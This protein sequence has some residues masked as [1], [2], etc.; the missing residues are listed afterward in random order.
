M[1]VKIVSVTFNMNTIQSTTAVWTSS[2]KITGSETTF[3]TIP[4]CE[5]RRGKD[6]ITVCVFSNQN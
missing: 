6:G 4:R 1:S 3:G 2:E 5:V